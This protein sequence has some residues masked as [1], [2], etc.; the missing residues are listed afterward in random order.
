[1]VIHR[2]KEGDYREKML[3]ECDY[4]HL[5]SV[6]LRNMDGRCSYYYDTGS[7]QSLSEC[8]AAS[9]MKLSDVRALAADLCDTLDYLQEHLLYLHLSEYSDLHQAVPILQV[10]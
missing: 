5:L 2:E 7:G 10:F 9:D 4:I 1:M 3:L 6:S 8:F